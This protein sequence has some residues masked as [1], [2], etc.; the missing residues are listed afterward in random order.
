MIRGLEDLLLRRLQ[1]DNLAAFQSIEV[2]CNEGG[3]RLLTE[4]CT[5]RTRRNIFKLKA[6]RYRLDTCMKFF[7][8][9]GG[10]TWKE[11][12]QRSCGSSIAGSIQGQIGWAWS[13][14][15]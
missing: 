15:V 4:A 14:L 2:A 13:N 12:A 7:Y 8:N 6:G 10:E 1:G 9:A 5:D 3:G 11:A